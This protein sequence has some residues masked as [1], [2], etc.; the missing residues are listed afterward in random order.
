MSHS[1]MFTSQGAKRHKGPPPHHVFGRCKMM[2]VVVRRL[3]YLFIYLFYYSI[4]GEYNSMENVPILLAPS[5]PHGYMA[6]PHIFLSTSSA[7]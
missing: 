3:F 4:F 5:H 6:K 1:F 7:P 2:F